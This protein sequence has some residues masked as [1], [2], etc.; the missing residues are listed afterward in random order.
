MNDHGCHSNHVD[1]ILGVPNMSHTVLIIDDEPGILGTV[2]G[3]LSDEGY[4][5]LSA[6]S[7]VKG[8]I[9]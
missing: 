5:T 2:A 6:S 8:L 4:S 9:L 3:V 1:Q 7:G